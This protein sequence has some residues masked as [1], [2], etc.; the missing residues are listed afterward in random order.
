MMF[1]HAGERFN[2]YSHLAATVLALA[3]G[4]YLLDRA[5]TAGNDVYTAGVVVFVL[6]AV[7]LYAA[8]TLYHCS[9][10]VA[11]LAW[12]RADHCAIYLLVAGSYTPFAL[13]AA[14]HALDWIVLGF[15]WMLALHGIRNEMTRERTAVP[16]LWVY[17]GMGWMGVVSVASFAGR[18]SPGVVGWLL[19]GAFFYSAG[20][21]FY[22]NRKGWAH[23]HGA[24]HVFV[25]CGTACHFVSIA[26]LVRRAG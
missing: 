15:M 1:I 21:V 8:S 17:L 19:A 23:A 2:G 22:R 11:R 9:R 18:L 24:W 16:P 25:M 10:S 26:G 13:M 6:C 3:G 7:V 14:H 20:T 12:E 4:A 5:V